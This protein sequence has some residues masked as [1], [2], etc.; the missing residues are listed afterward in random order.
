MM[1][2]SMRQVVFT[3]RRNLKFA[4][5][6]WSKLKPIRNEYLI[7][8]DSDESEALFNAL[9]LH[10]CKLCKTPETMFATLKDLDSHLR[11]K[12]ELF[13]CDLCVEHLRILS[14]ERKY[15]TRKEL[16]SHRKTGDPDDKSH[17]GHPLC[18][19]CDQRYLV[20]ITF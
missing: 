16:S 5:I 13:L 10:S 12:H 1:N 9:L 7:Y 3:S 2:I 18:K 11:K 8:F 19:F 6:E 14:H 17:R 20:S 4:D 15:Y